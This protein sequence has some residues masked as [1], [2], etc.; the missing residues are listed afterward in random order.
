MTWQSRTVWMIG[1]TLFLGLGTGCGVDDDDDGAMLLGWN[2]QYVED[3][4]PMD[5][6]GAGAVGEKTVRLDIRG[7]RSGQANQYD[8]R[9]TD[10]QGLTQRLAPD[11]YDV[12]VTL[13]NS[14]G[15]PLSSIQSPI[16]GPVEVRRHGA[17]PLPT[18]I[19]SVQSWI[20]NWTFVAPG[21][22]GVMRAATCEEVGVK[23][24]EFRPQMLPEPP[25]MFAF[26]CGPNL[27]ITTGIPTGNYSYNFRLLNAAGAP[28]LTTPIKGPVLVGKDL[29]PVVSELFVIP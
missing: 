19:F 15:V 3:M 16:D 27:G 18:I 22:G 26:E 17:T 4:T 8:F 5:C 28:V 6:A 2:L 21:P 10:G 11:F 1:I 14:Q 29:R 23:M 20:V 13:L 12:T 24:V 9:C 7:R 25:Q